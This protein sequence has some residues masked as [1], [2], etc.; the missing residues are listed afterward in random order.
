MQN[1]KIQSEGMR[2]FEEEDALI[3]AQLEAGVRCKWSWS[4]LNLESKCDVK[5]KECFNC[6]S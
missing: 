3:V 6:D 2:T 4:W 5:G 1:E